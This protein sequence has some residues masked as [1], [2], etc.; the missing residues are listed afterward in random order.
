[1]N[2]YIQRL[3]DFLAEQTPS[4]RYGD[5]NSVLEML[6]YYYTEANPVDNAVI[7]CQ[8]KD[9]NKVLSKLTL[10][11][12]EEV[13][14]TAVDLCISHARQAFTDGIVVGMRL[15]TELQNEAFTKTGDRRTVLPSPPEQMNNP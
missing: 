6:C 5:A 1:M 3:K 9:L 8:F 10:E 4:F 2:Y 13:F 14:S 7:R 15:F 11:D 12:S